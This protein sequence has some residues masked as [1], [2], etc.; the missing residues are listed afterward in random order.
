MKMAIW[1][2]FSF[3]VEFLHRLG[4]NHHLAIGRADNFPGPGV[5]RPDGKSLK[6]F[7]INRATNEIKAAVRSNQRFPVALPQTNRAIPAPRTG[8][9]MIQVSGMNG[10][11]TSKPPSVAVGL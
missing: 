10:S 2:A 5:G 7:R 3:Q 11:L 1:T 9:T 8:R 6:K 4:E